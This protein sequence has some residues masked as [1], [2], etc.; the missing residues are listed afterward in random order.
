MATNITRSDAK[1][2][3]GVTLCHGP[4]VQRSFLKGQ[5]QRVN[6][7]DGETAKRK[8]GKTE[9]RE[10]G[11]TGQRD[12][13]TTGSAGIQKPGC[14]PKVHR[15][16]CCFRSSAILE[17]PSPPSRNGGDKEG[18][19]RGRDWVLHVVEALGVRVRRPPHGPPEDPERFPAG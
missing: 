5:L 2:P 12:N 13:G 16:R 15:L 1:T 6:A 14:V 18:Y 11:T 4:F 19:F 3:R 17:T 8:D 10:N 7:Y 9:R